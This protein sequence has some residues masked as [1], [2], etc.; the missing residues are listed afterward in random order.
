MADLILK[1][2]E[3]CAEILRLTEETIIDRYPND[4]EAESIK[5][6]EL[7]EKREAM[8]AELIRINNEIGEIG[9]KNPCAET[10]KMIKRIIELDNQ[11]KSA[12]E[13]MLETAQEGIR[14]INK[15]RNT[16]LQYER[17]VESGGILVDNKT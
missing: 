15:G 3:L 1:R 12:G 14:R 7:Y 10:E 6:A 9:Q 17:R 11:N 13:M 4:A 2:R 16:S 8:V 5:Y